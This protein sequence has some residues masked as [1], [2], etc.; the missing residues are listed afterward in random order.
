MI[1]TSRLYNKLALA[2]VTDAAISTPKTP[3]RVNDLYADV[4]HFCGLDYARCTLQLSHGV[5][6]TQMGREYTGLSVSV[7]ILNALFGLGDKHPTT[8]AAAA[9]AATAAA[10]S[11]AARTLALP[12][13]LTASVSS[14]P[15][16][17]ASASAAAAAHDATLAAVPRPPCG[18]APEPLNKST[19]QNLVTLESHLEDVASSAD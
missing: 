16:A 12:T 6:F 13:P 15:S 1:E 14:S 5:H 10:G 3:L 17:S 19:S 11:P 9:A 18:E 2:A 8:A 7:A 4:T